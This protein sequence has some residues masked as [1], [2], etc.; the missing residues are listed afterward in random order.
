MNVDIGKCK[1]TE[2][3]KFKLKIKKYE[4]FHYWRHI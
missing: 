4:L 3:T 1:L 2:Q